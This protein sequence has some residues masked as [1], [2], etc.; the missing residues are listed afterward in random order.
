VLPPNER[1]FPFS[2]L[3][4]ELPPARSGKKCRLSTL[5]RWATRGARSPDGRLVRLEAARLGNRWVS[6]REAIARFMVALTPC[7]G[8]SPSRSQTS[9]GT[10]RT[11]SQRLK[12]SERAAEER[13]RRGV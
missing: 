5:I 12:A 4:E 9:A 6:T 7:P 8:E 10:P 11:P 3:A 1:V 13:E 2:V